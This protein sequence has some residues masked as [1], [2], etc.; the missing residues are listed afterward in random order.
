MLKLLRRTGRSGALVAATLAVVMGIAMCSVG[1]A[2]AS[3][4]H[5][6]SVRAWLAAHGVHVRRSQAGRREARTAIVGGNQISIEQAPWQVFVL[7]VLVEQEEFLLCGGSI[8]DATQI[9][10]AAHCLF[11]PDTEER[12]PAEDLLVVAG[13]SNFEAE[14][15]EQAQVQLVESLS[16]HP[17]YDHSAGAGA[18]DDVAVMTLSEGFALSSAPGSAVSSIG[19]VGAGAT[20]AEGTQLNL[21][22]FGL[23]NP[24]AGFP[25]GPL[26]SIRMTTGF[27]WKCG[28]EADAV[29]LCASAST[30]SGCFGD[31]GSGLTSTEAPK[32]LVG[33]MDTVYGTSHEFCRANSDNG[34]VNLTAPEIRDFIEGDSSPPQAPRGGNAIEVRGIPKVGNALACSPGGWSGEPT[35]AYLFIDS[36]SGQVLQSG[37]SSTYPLSS[38]DVGRTILCEVQATNAGGT[39]VVRTTSLRAIEAGSPPPP[40]LVPPTPPSNPSPSPSPGGGTA[41]NGTGTAG[42][43]TGISPVG[44]GG[45]EAAKVHD[46]GVA[47][48]GTSLGVQSGGVALAKLNCKEAEGCN[49][50]LTLVAKE[51]VR[52]KAHGK[53][54]RTLKIGTATFSLEAGE[55]GTVKIH[56][57]ATGRALLGAG[58][59]HLAASM[60]IEETEVHTWT[61]G[62]R[63]VAQPQKAKGSHKRRG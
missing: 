18:S 17:Y 23:E 48:T 13:I 56:L 41:A 27:S 36:S 11:N 19:L 42:S 22:G 47:L 44:S 1:M 20:P 14:H 10:T 54:K 2:S 58:H 28:G 52:S 31:S 29:W 21:T 34:F 33:V 4:P 37:A 32:A 59:G 25:E 55:T 7:G 45:V 57:N 24:S 40:P 46:E 5:H 51:T 12:L 9:V 6:Q 8:V 62:V 49:G 61:E 53:T 26:N 43:G 35:I 63:L 60:A 30:G 38:G 50:T 39:G 3:Q 16:V 15:E